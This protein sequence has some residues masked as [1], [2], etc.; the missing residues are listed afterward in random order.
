M[1]LYLIRKQLKSE[2]MEIKKDLSRREFVKKT[3]VSGIAFSIIPAH[4]L[5]GSGRIAPSDKINVGIIGCG[6]EGIREM[7]HLLPEK[8]VQ[9]VAVCDP[10]T[11]SNDYVEWSKNE[12][13]NEIRRV[14]GPTW[15]EGVNGVC[16]GREVGR[17]IVETYYA[18]ESPSMSYKGCSSY[19]DFRELLEKER[20]LDAVRILTPDHS[21]ATIAIAAMKKN[22]HVAMHKPIANRVYEA[23]LV[24]TVARETGVGTH[25][26]AWQGRRSTDLV[27]DWILNGAIGTLREIH[28]WTPVPQWPQWPAY[29][30]E[31][32]PVP[33][34]FEWD[35]WLG[36]VLDR[37]YHPNF[38]H[39]LY[40]GWYD[41]GGGALADMGVYSLWPVF[42]SFNLGTPISI[43]TSGT[44]TSVINDSVSKWQK[45]DVAFPLACKIRFRFP[46][47]GEWQPI[48][49]FWYDGGMKPTTPEELEMD[50]KEMPRVGLMFVG[51]K[52]VI[53]NNRIIP[54][55]KMSEYM[56]GKETPQEQR[57][58]SGGDRIWIDA[59][60]GR[61]PSEGNFLN[62]RNVSETLCLGAVALQV[63]RRID[64]DSKNMKITNIPE[65]DKYLYREYRKGWEL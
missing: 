7:L 5:G 22:K 17:E 4:V 15:L 52:G 26:I 28:Y 43:E 31:N 51:D 3:A 1:S 30:T 61:Q 62:A 33:K 59:F 14:L 12:R 2:N 37:P 21:H 45:N 44:T 35:L 25:S 16:A 20:D 27:R 55:K 39:A 41:F 60:K 9:I 65:A 57:P 64:W 47:Q 50:N 34:G 42:M 49:L 19:V 8:D 54:E 46:A 6:T 10:N 40:R 29:P 18:K 32:P 58:G 38:T 11:K 63:G 13:R 48:D 23:R 56:E 24:D 53:L 36:P